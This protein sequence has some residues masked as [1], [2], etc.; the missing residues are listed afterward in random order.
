MKYPFALGGV[1][2]AVALCLTAHAANKAKPSPTSTDTDGVQ[3]SLQSEVLETNSS[4]NRRDG[5]AVDARVSN[6]VWWHAGYLISGRRWLPYEA[7]VATGNDSIQLDEYRELREKLSDH[8]HGQ[9]KLA[10]WCRKTG[11]VDQ[12]R[13]HLL[14]V[15]ASRD[16]SV[17]TETVYQRLGC[18]KI[19]GVWVSE[20]ER[21]EAAALKSEIE[22]SHQRWGSKLAL[23]AQNL[24]GT[25]KQRSQAEQR[26]AEITQPSAVPAIVS[27][28]CLSTQT[29]AEYGVKTLGQIREYQASRALAGQAVFS[30][31]K[32][33]RTI[34]IEL[35]R[36]RK[37]TEFAPDM[38]MLLVNPVQTKV[39]VTG[40]VSRSNVNEDLMA[41]PNWQ[42]NWDYVWVEETNESIRVGVRR[43]FPLSVPPK[44]VDI[45]SNWNPERA[46]RFDAR[47]GQRIASFGSSNLI[48]SVELQTQADALNYSADKLNDGRKE[49]NERVGKVL[50]ASTGNELTSNP[51]DWWD[52]WAQY[53]DVAPQKNKYVE[54]IDERP[55]I[56]SFSRVAVQ[57]SCLVA[58]TPVWT[59]RGPVAIELIRPGDRVLA[60]DV[61]SGELSYKPVL[62]T[63][64]REPTQVQTFTVEGDT[65]VASL[66]HHFWVSGEGWTKMRDLAAKKPLHTVAGMKRITGVENENR[67]A[68]VYNLVVA[69]FHTY[70]VGKSM[71]L[72]HDVLSPTL[73][74]VKVP[75]LAIR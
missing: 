1:C 41:G 17:N 48:A 73:T 72:S 50:A 10:N 38:L 15:L 26:L 34:A 29:M 52:W 46:G 5:L 62:I 45:Y 49:M 37:L 19:D 64:V 30:P 60:K 9:W 24:D 75:G 12:E 56:P 43:L 2:V 33:V 57:R 13:V 27:T 32:P 61:V 74:N 7:S 18:R 51:K 44:V 11:M 54:V 3:A 47:T 59:E 70:F 40:Q 35:L 4:V 71:V 16:P 20:Y 65:I 39:D 21:R 69:D 14:R 58:G 42:V 31:W 63:T 68:S 8:P 53:S 55:N 28:F 67:V 22:Q 66:G 25:Q 23:L 36:S 6:E